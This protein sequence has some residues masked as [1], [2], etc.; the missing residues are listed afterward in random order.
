VNA[1]VN[2]PLSVME[3]NK[4]RRGLLQCERTL[5]LAASGQ[6]AASTTSGTR[7]PPLLFLYFSFARINSHI[8][9]AINILCVICLYFKLTLQYLADRGCSGPSAFRQVSLRTVFQRVHFLATDE[10]V[11]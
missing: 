9:L 4:R 10:L 6:G 7:F 3:G 11:F 8:P 1:T 5:T 2:K